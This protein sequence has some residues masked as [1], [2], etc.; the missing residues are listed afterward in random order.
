MKLKKCMKRISAILLAAT[1]VV[2]ALPNQPV[3]KADEDDFPDEILFPVSIL[4]FPADNLF[5]E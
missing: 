3:V 5:F 1:M 2:V 4:D